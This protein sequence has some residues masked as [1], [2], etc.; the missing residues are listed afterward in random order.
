MEPVLFIK[1]EPELGGDIRGIW[2][3]A[4]LSTSEQT[5]MLLNYGSTGTTNANLRVSANGATVRMRIGASD[6]RVAIGRTS[7]DEQLHVDENIKCGTG[8]ATSVMKPGILE[9]RKDSTTGS[10]IRDHL[11]LNTAGTNSFDG[12]TGIFYRNNTTNFVTRYQKCSSAINSK[13]LHK[14][15]PRF[16]SLE[17]A[18]L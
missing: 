14:W 9:I 7:A 6:R 10:I 4:N 1:T 15:T 18:A 3:L 13:E 5:G 11:Y 16:L 12:D 2:I 8:Q 17:S